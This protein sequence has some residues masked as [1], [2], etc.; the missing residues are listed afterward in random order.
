M[1]HIK[2]LTGLLSLCFVLSACGGTPTPGGSTDTRTFTVAA[3]G[4]AQALRVGDKATI[5]VTVTPQGGFTGSVTADLVGAPPGVSAFPVTANV[6][7]ATELKLTVT[8]GTAAGILRLPVRVTGGNVTRD[9]DA[10]AVIYRV[11]TLP[12]GGTT[13]TTCRFPAQDSVISGGSLW[14]MGSTNSQDRGTLIRTDLASGQVTPF[15]TLVNDKYLDYS[16]QYFGLAQSGQTLWSGFNV[17]FYKPRLVGLNTQTGD[18]WKVEVGDVNSTIVNMA[19]LPDGRVAFL[20]HTQSNDTTSSVWSIGLFDPATAVVTLTPLADGGAFLF[21]LKV[22]PDGQLWTS[23]GYASPSLVRFNPTTLAVKRFPIGVERDNLALAIAPV[24]N[25]KVWYMDSRANELV[26]LNPVDGSVR[27][28]KGIN[29]LGTLHAYGNGVFFADGG[30]VEKSLKF[31]TED[32]AGL[33]YF[34]FPTLRGVSGDLDAFAVGEDGSLGYESSGEAY[35]L[36]AN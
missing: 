36:P 35:T 19:A 24:A 15:S 2:P 17:S 21:D 25:G 28:F 16:G 11:S 3:T 18:L 7:G 34:E 8:T 12:S 4:P 27:R 10:F 5:T 20:Y 30:N 26:I 1:A 6:S 29:P 13:C 14:L 33:S 23:Q 32:T 22:G 31:L 9:D